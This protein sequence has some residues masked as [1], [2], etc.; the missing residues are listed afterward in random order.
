MEYKDENEAATQIAREEKEG[1]K[2]N[3]E[4]PDPNSYTEASQ[5]LAEELNNL[6]RG[7]TRW[8]AMVG[9]M[10]L[11]HDDEEYI[12]YTTL[13]PF[14]KVELYAKDHNGLTFAV[15][16]SVDDAIKFFVDRKLV[17]WW[18]CVSGEPHYVRE[19]F[20]TTKDGRT[21]G[22][23]QISESPSNYFD[24]WCAD[25]AASAFLRGVPIS[26]RI[27]DR[28][29]LVGLFGRVGAYNL[30]DREDRSKHLLK[31]TLY[32]QP[33]GKPRTHKELIV[34]VYVVK[35]SKMSK[36]L[37]KLIKEFEVWVGPNTAFGRKYASSEQ[38]MLLEGRD[39]FV[40]DTGKSELQR[41]LKNAKAKALVLGK[42]ALLLQLLHQ[43]K[44]PGTVAHSHCSCHCSCL[45]F[46]CYDTQP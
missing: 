4:V 32:V 17:V 11:N 9:W 1:E 3:D 28:L 44:E 27:G 12:E 20:Y 42:R 15:A 41:A 43:E 18:N 35:G 23:W 10:A 6:K 31:H 22:W 38:H 21:A 26:R 2:S 33:N 46:T 14:E 45:R 37:L 36:K 19:A 16:C 8:L 5:R 25:L 39:V 24:Y 29:E 13:I 7:S 40:F 30:K 34:T